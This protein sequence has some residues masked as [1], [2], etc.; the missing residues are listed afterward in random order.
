[1]APITSLH[2]PFEDDFRRR[3]LLESN[4]R[5]MDLWERIGFTMREYQKHVERSDSIFSVSQRD[6][7]EIGEEDRRL[8]DLP[9]SRQLVTLDGCEFYNNEQGE[10]GEDLEYGIITITGPLDDWTMTNN[11][12]HDNEFGDPLDQVSMSVAVAAATALRM[13]ILTYI[14]LFFGNREDMPS[15]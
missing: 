11:Y 13:L 1:M 3:R 4:V 5:E 8:D 15:R 7:I 10:S 14:F 12:F 6:E 2:L 9:L